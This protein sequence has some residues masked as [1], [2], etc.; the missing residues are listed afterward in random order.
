MVFL[1]KVLFLFALCGGVFAFFLKGRTKEAFGGGFLG[2]IALGFL[3]IFQFIVF[4][5]MALIGIWLIAR[6]F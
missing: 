2:G 4:G 5:F 6:I 1:F 3:T